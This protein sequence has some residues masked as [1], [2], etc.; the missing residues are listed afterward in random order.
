MFNRIN[1][2]QKIFVIIGTM[3]NKMNNIQKIFVIIGTMAIL[4][5]IIYG[6][7]EGEWIFKTKSH[8][9]YRRT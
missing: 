5:F 2:I 9:S 4:S 7:V 1:S 6:L 8:P 3:V